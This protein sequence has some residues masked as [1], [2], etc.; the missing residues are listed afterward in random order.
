[1]A[2]SKTDSATAR[3]RFAN[4][5][6]LVNDAAKSMGAVLSGKQLKRVTSNYVMFGWDESL[7]RDTLAQYVKWTSSPQGGF[8]GQAGADENAIHAVAN[9]NGL[10]YGKGTYQKWLQQ[11]AAGNLQVANIQ[12]QIRAQAAAAFPGFGDQLK[13]GMDLADVAS[14]YT[15][16]MAQILELNAQDIDL[17]DP[18]L[19]KALQGSTDPK[20]APSGPKPLWQFEQDL[21]HDGRWLKT[22]NSQDS[23]MNAT[24]R[25][26]TD[27]GLV[28]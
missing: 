8:L 22:K 27:M 24:R 21:R 7:L 18:T 9:A 25:V 26:L 2:L 12:D 6:A 20:G 28:S 19:R 15:N 4:A 14:P 23:L 17:F 3:D 5:K 10:R 13:A 1:V 11:I 16:S